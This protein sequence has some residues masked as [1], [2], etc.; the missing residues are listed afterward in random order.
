MTAVVGTRLE[1]LGQIVRAQQRHPARFEVRDSGAHYRPEIFGRRHVGDGIVDEHRVERPRKPEGPHVSH[2]LLQLWIELVA[3]AKH[4]GRQVHEHHVERGL[5][6]Q[7]VRPLTA[8]ELEHRSYIPV[9]MLADL[10]GVPRRFFLVVLRCRQQ[11]VPIRELRV[12][13]EHRGR[14]ADLRPHAG[15]VERRQ[16]RSDHIMPSLVTHSS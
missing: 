13:L 11:R 16:Q 5:H 15:C 3:Q 7:G 14:I 2:M 8:A 10:S 4:L 1:V 9:R 6:V 12:E